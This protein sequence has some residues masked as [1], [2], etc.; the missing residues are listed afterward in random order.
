MPMSEPLLCSDIVE[1]A[2]EAVIFADRDGRIGLWN[3]AAEALFG[4]SAAEAIGASLD[5]IVP[6]RFRVA[7]WNGFRKAIESGRTQHGGEVRTTRSLHKDG[8][9]LYVELSFGLVKTPAGEVAGSL[10]IGRCGNERFAKDAE[11][12]ARIAALE[13]ELAGLRAPPIQPTGRF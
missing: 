3:R 5:L 1:Q 13:S 2:W 8:R 10:A 9:K 11:L 6:E 12:R 7:H 4:F